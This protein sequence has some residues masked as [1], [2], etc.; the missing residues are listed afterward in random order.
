MT[1]DNQP[2]HRQLFARQVLAKAGL[3]RKAGVS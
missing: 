1:F 2:Y 3:A